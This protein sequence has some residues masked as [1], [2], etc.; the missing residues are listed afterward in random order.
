MATVTFKGTNVRLKGSFPLVGQKAPDFCLVNGDLQ[1]Q[2]LKDFPTKK[3]L[4]IVPSLDTE[5]CAKSSKQ[6]SEQIQSKKNLSLLLISA[7]LPFAQKRYC[8]AK[9]VS[10]AMTLSMMRDKSF[11]E[12]YGVL[13]E[14]GP[15]AGLCT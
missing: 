7:D 14:D 11:A 15:L 4:I 12:S 3:L 5:V 13:I 2:T 10:N 8:G 1:N 6:F 9:E